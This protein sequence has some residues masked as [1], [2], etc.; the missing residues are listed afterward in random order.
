MKDHGGIYSP[1]DKP[2]CPIPD[3]AGTHATVRNGVDIAGGQKGTAG[4]VDE[5]TLVGAA[6]A[7]SSPGMGQPRGIASPAPTPMPK[8]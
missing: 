6:G 7:G 4:V 2:V 3:Q 5:V 1:F 8:F